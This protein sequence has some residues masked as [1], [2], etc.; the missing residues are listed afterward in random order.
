M[1]DTLRSALTFAVVVALLVATRARPPERTSQPRQDVRLDVAG[2]L[3]L[4]PT[5]SRRHGSL[6]TDVRV[7]LAAPPQWS[8]D[9]PVRRFALVEAPHGTS[10]VPSIRLL[11]RSSRG[12]PA[13][14]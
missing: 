14:C 1:R 2:Q 6:D 12:P 3:A 10:T 4:S 7:Q 9:A 8:E 13:G 11:P 5:A